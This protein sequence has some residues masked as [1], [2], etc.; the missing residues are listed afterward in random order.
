MENLNSQQQLA[1][2]SDMIRQA[3][4][5]VARDSSSQILLWGWVIAAANFGHFTLDQIGFYAPFVVWLIIIPATILSIY[6]GYKQAQPGT[7]AHLDKVYGNVWMAVG[8]SIGLTLLMMRELNAFHNPIIMSLAATGMFISG[9]LLKY[10]PVVLGSVILW[11][12]A[13]LEWQVA[14]EYHYLISGIAVVL[15]YLIPG[16]MLKK[17]EQ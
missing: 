2:I 4:S 3:K 14:I 5:S 7:S 16:Y 12:A 6:M 17:S 13:L 11:V 15:G 10:K 1:L 9:K 8:I